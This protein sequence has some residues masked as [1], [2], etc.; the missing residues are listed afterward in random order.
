LGPVCQKRVDFELQGI[1]DVAVMCH[2][3]GEIPPGFL[4]LLLLFV[5]TTFVYASFAFG[6]DKY[7][8]NNKNR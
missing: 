8:K 7:K 3:V 1:L 2:G 6:T 4:K 5:F